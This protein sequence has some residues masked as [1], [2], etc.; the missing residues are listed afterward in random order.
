[1]YLINDIKVSIYDIY[2]LSINNPYDTWLFDAWKLD[3][4]PHGKEIIRV[5][6][7][8]IGKALE[9]LGIYSPSD[10]FEKE[11]KIW[12]YLKT[13]FLSFQNIPRKNHTQ[14]TTL[15]WWKQVQTW[16]QRFYDGGK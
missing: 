14:I 8:L 13:V 11:S 3:Q 16:L 10:L 12:K 5:E 1:M 2:D 6:F 7:E 15:K 4:V 9:T